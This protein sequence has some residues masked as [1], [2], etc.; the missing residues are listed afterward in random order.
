MGRPILDIE[1]PVSI[2]GASNSASTTPLGDGK[3]TLL[4]LSLAM[5]AVGAVLAYDIGGI[6][7]RSHENNRGFTPWGRKTTTTFRNLPRPYKIVGWV[8]LIPGALLLLLAVI[9]I[10]VAL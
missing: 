5:V 10:L 1:L 2:Y 8:F 4:L 7:S 6:A 9:A 3:L